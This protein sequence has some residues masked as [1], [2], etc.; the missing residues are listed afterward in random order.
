MTGTGADQTLSHGGPGNGPNY[1]QA[2]GEMNMA[3]EW[4]LRRYV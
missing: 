3:S 4:E 1:F 2:T